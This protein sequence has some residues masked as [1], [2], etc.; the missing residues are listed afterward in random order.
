MQLGCCCLAF[1]A[2]SVTNAYV[3]IVVT[4]FLTINMEKIVQWATI[5]SP[6]IA[7]IVAW[8][9]SRS[10]AKATEK[11]IASIKELARIQIETTQL[12]INK[13]LW[14]ARALYFQASQK[15]EDMIERDRFLYQVGGGND[16]FR[17]REE[18]KKNIEYEGDFHSK[19]TQVLEKF[20]NRLNELSKQL[21]KM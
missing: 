2:E 4:N 17:N 20:Q 9:M 13:E 12:Q 1:Y 21:E 5:L 19:Q 15:K 18:K 8:W 6:I 14:E 10:S 16:Y 3:I 7:V 11:Q